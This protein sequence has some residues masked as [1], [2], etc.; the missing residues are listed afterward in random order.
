MDSKLSRDEIDDAE[1]V[2]QGSVGSVSVMGRI[3]YGR[4]QGG[5]EKMH[6][7]MGKGG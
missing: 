1:L 2:S 7:E 3:G 6:S 4:V 5:L